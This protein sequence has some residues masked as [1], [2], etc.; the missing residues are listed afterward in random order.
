[1]KKTNAFSI[2]SLKTTRLGLL[3]LTLLSATPL[4][5]QRLSPQTVHVAGGYS[6]AADF[7]L[8]YNVGEQRSVFLH[9]RYRKYAVR[10]VPAGFR[11]SG[12]RPSGARPVAKQYLIRGEYQTFV[13]SRVCGFKSSIAVG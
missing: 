5:G 13:Y 10:R 12:A 11:L 6:K 9:D 3:C 8:A 4:Q 2:T 1:M 7:S